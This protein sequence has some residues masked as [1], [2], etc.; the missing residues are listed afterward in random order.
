MNE[1]FSITLFFDNINH[2][3]IFFLI[4]QWIASMSQPTM[5]IRISCIWICGDCGVWFIPFFKWMYVFLVKKKKKE[6]NKI[7]S[8]L[9]PNVLV[10]PF[11]SSL[12]SWIEW[13]GP[14]GY[15]SETH[16]G[17]MAHGCRRGRS[18]TRCIGSKTHLAVELLNG[19]LMVARCSVMHLL[20]LKLKVK[21]GGKCS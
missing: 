12:S 5:K 14:L 10:Y 17:C 13:L 18:W 4:I 11:P 20:C 9:T 21:R 6:G 3:F 16:G 1:I 8:P 19:S 15:H 2:F 7:I